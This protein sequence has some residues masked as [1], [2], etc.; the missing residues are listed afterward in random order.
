MWRRQYDDGRIS[1]GAWG[2]SSSPSPSGLSQATTALPSPPSLLSPE[3]TPDD[4][5]NLTSE[6]GPQGEEAL[7]GSPDVTSDNFCVVVHRGDTRRLK[8][9][10]ITKADV[11]RTPQRRPT[12]LNPY[13]QGGAV[14]SP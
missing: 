1:G 2:R 14:T 10:G 9:G 7:D 12:D 11:D 5:A 4:E 3:G 6:A 8:R 13:V